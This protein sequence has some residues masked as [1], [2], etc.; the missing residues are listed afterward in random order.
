MAS[1]SAAG[2]SAVSQLLQ[3]FNSK[4]KG[5]HFS[6]ASAFGGSQS[7]KTQAGASSLA[8]KIT[9][10][11]SQIHAQSQKGFASKLKSATMPASV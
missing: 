1:L 5:G 4:K 10:S 8:A 6:P 11:N 7:S 2:S 9:A 3:Q